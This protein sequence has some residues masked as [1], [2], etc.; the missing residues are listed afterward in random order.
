MKVK[1]FSHVRLFVTPWTAAYQAPPSMGFSRQEYWSGV[2]LPSPWIRLNPCLKFFNESLLPL[3]SNRNSLESFKIWPL[4]T[5]SLRTSYSHEVPPLTPHLHTSTPLKMHSC[6][7]WFFH[8]LQLV[9]AHLQNAAQKL[10]SKMLSIFLSHPGLI[11]IN[12][13]TILYPAFCLPSH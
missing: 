11:L 10:S 9:L 2:P 7:E 8:F 13:Y 12:V 5:S 4:F 6:L 1:L 3:G